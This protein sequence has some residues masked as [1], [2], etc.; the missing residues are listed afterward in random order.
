VAGGGAG[1]RHCQI[2]GN[3][4]GAGGGGCNG[5]NASFYGSG[6]GGGGSSSDGGCATAGNGY[7]GVVVL[8]GSW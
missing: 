3:L 7:P 4:G 5:K 8:R 1:G 6:G 2:S